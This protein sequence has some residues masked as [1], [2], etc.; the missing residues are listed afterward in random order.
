MI[1]IT[2]KT[3]NLI[4]GHYYIGQHATLKINDGYLGSGIRIKAAI[5][6]HGRQNF[7]REVLGV[8][9][10]REDMNSAEISL[11][12]PDVLADPLCY[13]LAP[14]GSGS[15]FGSVRRPRRLTLISK[16]GEEFS[17][18]VAELS[19]DLGIPKKKIYDVAHG[20]RGHYRGFRL[21]S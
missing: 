15:H 20:C 1:F 16:T 18:T 3:T 6:K 17:G 10:T 21:A 5:K 8:Y 19:A 11:I 2:Y 14:G 12:T 7:E 13:N 4:N 9:D